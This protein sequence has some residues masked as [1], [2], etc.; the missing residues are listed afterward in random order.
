MRIGT[1]I[2][3]IDGARYNY[4]NQTEENTYKL[5]SYCFNYKPFPETVW[6]NIYNLPGTPIMSILGNDA[7]KSW[8]NAF[9]NPA[10]QMVKVAYS[11]PENITSGNLHLFDNSGRPLNQFIVD[12]HTDH[13]ELNISEYKSGIYHYFIE[14]GNTKTTSK[15]LVI[16]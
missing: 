12:N 16:R 3:T 9:P 14:Y 5:F 4:I 2:L 6:T 7:P 15:K 8:I 10:S 11:L 1:T 13:L